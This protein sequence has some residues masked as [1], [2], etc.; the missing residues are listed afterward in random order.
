[1]QAADRRRAGGPELHRAASW[2]PYQAPG[3]GAECRTRCYIQANVSD[4]ELCSCAAA[5]QCCARGHYQGQGHHH[6]QHHTPGKGRGRSPAGLLRGLELQLP[7]VRAVAAASEDV[8][9]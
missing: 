4:R 5:A 8:G 7:H 3:D 2:S 9:S 1:V 6:A